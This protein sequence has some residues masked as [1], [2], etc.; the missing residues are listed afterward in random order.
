MK[1]AESADGPALADD[2]TAEV[3]PQ[4]TPRHRRWPL[5]LLTLIV[6]AVV[7][8][9]LMLFGGDSPSSVSVPYLGGDLG[10]GTQNGQAA[11]D[12]SVQLLDGTEFRLSDHVASNDRPIFL[13]LWASWCAPCRAEMPAIDAAAAR[14]TDV[15]FLGVAVE[16]DPAAARG[17]AEEIAVSYPLAIDDAERVS[18]R[19]PSPGL[20]ATFLIA[21]D[22]TI[23]RTVFGG[24]EEEDID[25]LVAESFGL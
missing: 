6:V 10:L 16:D 5:G 3:A 22:G 25:T 19:Y 18:R 11:P 8:V 7:V 17:F 4:S 24:L 9:G 12:F 1:P 2:A 14:H 13:N 21:P 23:V 20:P 15:Y